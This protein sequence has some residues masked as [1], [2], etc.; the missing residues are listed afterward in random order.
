[1]RLAQFREIEGQHRTFVWVVAAQILL[2]DDQTTHTEAI[3][4]GRASFGGWKCGY[5]Q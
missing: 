1:M 4:A 3:L 5:N 2:H